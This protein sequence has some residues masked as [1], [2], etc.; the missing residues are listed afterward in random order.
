MAM[1]SIRLKGLSFYSLICVL[2]GL[3]SPA[4]AVEVRGVEKLSDNYLFFGVLILLAGFVIAITGWTRE[5]KRNAVLKGRQLEVQKSRKKYQMIVDKAWDGI[6]IAQNF[7]IKYANLQIYKIMGLEK[8]DLLSDNLLDYIFPDDLGMVLEHYEKIM[9]ASDEDVGFTM[10]ILKG[11]KSLHWVQVRS[12]SILFGGE[13][14]NLSFIRDITE[15]KHMEGDLYQAQRLEAIGA[16]SGGIVHDFNNILTIIL[17]NAELAL[18]DLTKE[19]PN[20]DAFRQIQVSGH[21]ARQ[22]VR[23]ILTLSRSHF[24][25]I[26]PLHLTSVIKEVL[27]LLKSTLPS[28]IQI[29]EIIDKNAG[30]VNVDPTRIYQV[31]MNLCTNAKYAMETKSSGIL[32]VRLTRANL[33]GGDP[34]NSPA[35][36]A[37][38]YI[39]LSVS[40]NGEGIA[41]EIQDKI[42]HPYF[43]T[44]GQGSC[45]GLG[46]S[47]S[48]GIIKKCGGDIVWQSEP[49]NGSKFSVFL[50]VHEPPLPVGIRI[51][52]LSRRSGSGNILFV[53]DEKEIL[54]IVEKTF[55]IFGYTVITAGSGKKALEY[56]T[57]DPV[58]F[59]LVIT[60]MGMPGMTGEQLSRKIAKIRPDLPVILCTGH[61]DTFDK[62]KALK[63]GIRE[64]IN[65][66]YSLKELSVLVARYI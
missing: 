46:L 55:K 3:F 26:I 28:N 25:E 49:G 50:P 42:F 5:K 33:P 11:D 6:L 23:Q 57:K 7:T 30:M 44:R 61:S 12:V 45:A 54:I 32:D 47:T 51:D 2:S 37:G 1:F 35:L 36:P 27:K 29:V 14:A 15:F 60:D 43:T 24:G 22:L 34:E 65:K 17:T 62:Q 58:F 41:P 4:L 20:Y 13:P 64:H 31:F 39:K 9:L 56:L 10:R 38:R 19:N 63:F 40:D 59:D 8:G 16:L 53:D 18:M 48:L 52:D 21:R 66:P